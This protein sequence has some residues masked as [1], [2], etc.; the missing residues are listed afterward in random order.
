ML[1]NDPNN[2]ACYDFLKGLKETY[3]K[4]S[5]QMDS[6]LSTWIACQRLMIIEA[7]KK[8]VEGDCTMFIEM[9]QEHGNIAMLYETYAPLL[10]KIG[11]ILTYYVELYRNL[12]ASVNHHS[13]VLLQK[14]FTKKV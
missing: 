4:A 11:P 6:D 5:L 12:N 14:C 1:K 13:C 9:I 10:C 3:V 2:H 7:L 8:P